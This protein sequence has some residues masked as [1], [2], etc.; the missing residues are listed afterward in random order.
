MTHTW[1][2]LTIGL[3]FA[4]SMLWP[5]RRRIRRIRIWQLL[6]IEVDPAP[7]DSSSVVP[8]TGTRSVM[9]RRVPRVGPSMKN[10]R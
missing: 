9:T 2:T 7:A 4:A 6:D 3:L 8:S 1:L 5:I 10:R